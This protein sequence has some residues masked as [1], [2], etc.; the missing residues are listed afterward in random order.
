MAKKKKAVP[1]KRL[2]YKAP[3][4]EEH[5]DDLTEASQAAVIQKNLIDLSKEEAKLMS[6]WVK[7]RIDDA[8]GSKVW[9]ET[10]ERILRLR[11]EYAKGVPRTS[12][13]MKGAHDYRTGFAAT[14]ADGMTAR[15]LSIFSVDP[16]LKFEGRNQRGMDNARNVEQFVDY[17][18]DVNAN[19]AYKG[20]EISSTLTIEGHEVL[21]CPWILE[22]EK[23]K[24]VLVEKQ[25][26]TNGEGKT[27]KIDIENKMALEQ[28]KTNGFLPK[29]PI[30]FIVEEEKRTEVLKNY[31]DLKTFSLLD[32]L[33]PPD[34]KPGLD[35]RPSWEAVRLPFTL[36]D[37]EKMD[38]NKQLYPGVLKEIKN[39]L[40]K[41]PME[42]QKTTTSSGGNG[43]EDTVT[44][45]TDAPLD[46][47]GLDSILP[48]W[49]IWGK[50]FIPGKRRL[51]NVAT[52]YHEDSGMV[53]QSRYNRNIDPHPPMFHLRFLMI[54]FR[55]AGMGIMEL[56]SPGER[57]I[58][59]LANYILDEGRI[60]ACLPYK[61]N[62]KRFPGG[63]PPFEFWKGLGVTNMKDVEALQFPDRRPMDINVASFV[64]SHAERRT[65]QG[66]L[67][68]GRES[69]ATGKTPPTARGIISILREG[70]VRYTKINFG[71]INELTR[72]GQF[73]TKLFQQYLG[74]E[75]PVEILGADGV[76]LFPKGMSRTQ[77][78]GSFYVEANMAAQQMARELDAELNI[79]LYTL[80][81]N[82]PF[83][84]KSMSSFYDMTVD[85]L[86][87]VGKRG[88]LWVKDLSFYK[89]P[90][91]DQAGGGGT[92]PPGSSGLTPDE[93]AF[94]QHLLK[95][96]V[97]PEEARAQL[98]QLRSGGTPA[99]S[100]EAA[101]QEAQ[102]ADQQLLTAGGEAA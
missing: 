84:A 61:Y 3:P 76:D 53:L 27:L 97:S 35:Q 59:D 18:H 54:P 89:N 80:F 36:D 69:E 49:I 1:S 5:P 78:M 101:G 57:A 28:A 31:P 66:D 70:Q 93:Q 4:V 15:V 58:N 52:I 60:M 91:G 83:I 73:I 71:I 81:Q 86:H 43:G 99:P 32:Y 82:N 45:T 21:Y 50:Q 13:E 72:Y 12:T 25:V 24:T 22:I 62:K 79:Q 17:H 88:K 38:E 96:G 63:L 85:V 26:L 48:C 39:Y 77:I 74:A 9:T 33:C 2:G 10:K 14:Q 64:R 92:K 30:S 41:K 44:E 40:K 98:E 47:E 87:S 42:M 90:Q 7:L 68:L 65:G 46:K 100:P 20:D 51:Q 19:L 16:L 6:A 102:A 95:A 75:T 37:L 11:E 67:Q 34:A 8:R 23:D 29:V 56:S 94:V 55:F